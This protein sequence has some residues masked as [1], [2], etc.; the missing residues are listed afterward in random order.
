VI[1]SASSNRSS[2][3]GKRYVRIRT[4]M[5]S[6]LLQLP[7]VSCSI[8]PRAGRSVRFRVRATHCSSWTFA[9]ASTAD[10]HPDCAGLGTSK[11]ADNVCTCMGVEGLGVWGDAKDG[12]SSSAPSST[13][14]VGANERFCHRY[15]HAQVEQGAKDRSAYKRTVMLTGG[16]RPGTRAFAHCTESGQ[17]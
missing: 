9:S 11:R 17:I 5:V 16:W 8:V 12:G 10:V 13:A 2:R 1:S 14:S 6:S 3:C 7:T 4:I 15:R